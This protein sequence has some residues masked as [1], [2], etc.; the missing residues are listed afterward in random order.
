MKAGLV[1]IFL[2]DVFNIFGQSYSSTGYPDAS[3]SG[4]TYFYP[5]AGRHARFGF[6]L[7]HWRER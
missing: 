1:L 4:H 5:A 6:Q 2:F 3:G 7:Q